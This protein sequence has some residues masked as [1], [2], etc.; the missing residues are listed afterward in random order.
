[1]P[2]SR[3]GRV[4][5]LL[6]SGQARII[7][8]DPFAIQLLY[9]TPEIVSTPLIGGI[10]PGSEHTP[11]ALVRPDPK[12]PAKAHVVIAQEILLRDDIHF[13]MTRRH[14]A[15]GPASAQ[16]AVPPRPVPQSRES[17]VL[18]LRET[19]HPEGLEEGAAQKRAQLQ[20]DQQGPRRV[21][22]RL[23]TPGA[24]PPRP[25]HDAHDLAPNPHQ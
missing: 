6:Q 18:G 17:A 12:D 3:F 16:D 4:R 9:D 13:Q 20:V 7:S 5:H 23:S 1:M 21:V 15:P 25:A 2:T 8:H 11:I 22:S 10:D 24:A 14:V 19:P